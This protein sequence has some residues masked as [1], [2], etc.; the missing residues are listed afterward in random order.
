MFE[1]TLVCLIG[2][3]GVSEDIRPA[4]TTEVRVTTHYTIYK[5]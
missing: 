1:I 2:F 3:T 5:R 4:N